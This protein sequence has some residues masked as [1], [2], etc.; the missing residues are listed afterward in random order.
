MMICE[1][2]LRKLRKGDPGL[3]LRVFPMRP[4]SYPVH[5]RL[6]G[7]AWVACGLLV[8]E[9]LPVELARR[10]VVLYSNNLDSTDSRDG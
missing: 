4:Y 7:A 6:Y 1:I 3:H 2:R 10:L 9:M 5:N 8:R